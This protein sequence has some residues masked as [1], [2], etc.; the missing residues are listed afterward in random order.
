MSNKS[1]L[2]ESTR[3]NGPNGLQ[4]L[5]PGF[6]FIPNSSFTEDNN[7]ENGLDPKLIIAML[8]RYKWIVLLFLVM[9]G[10][11]A[12]LYADFVT[13]TYQSKGTLLIS[14][15]AS[16]DDL[17]RIV[18]QTT[19]VGAN[20]TLENELQILKSRSFSNQIANKISTDNLG[21]HTEYPILWAEEEDGS[22]TK[23]SVDQVASRIRNG[24]EFRKV[25]DEADIIEISFT[26]SSPKEAALIVNEAMD[27][28]VQSSIDQNRQAADSTAEFLKREKEKN[29]RK[30]EEAEQKLAK[31]MDTTGIVQVDEQ[32]STLVNER[33]NT[34]VELQ[35]VNLEIQTI[36]QTISNYEKELEA[37][38]PGLS[39]QFSEAIG[40]RIRASQ[41]ELARHE[42][43]R[44]LIIAKNPGVLDRRPVPPRLEYLDKQIV[45][46]KNEIKDLSSRLFT[47]DNTF[48]GLDGEDRAQK[49]AEIEGR[50][51]D[52][53]IQRNQY[54]SRRAAL[55]DHKREMDSNFNELPEGMIQL[56]KLKRDVRI[57]EELYT[58][59][60]KKY[61]D[62][63][64][65][66]QSQ[67]GYGRIIDLG[68]EP[69][70]PVSPNK[71]LFILLGLMLGGFLAAAYITI[72]E[73]LDDSV[74]SADQLR[75]IYVP[76]VTLTMIPS[77]ENVSKKNKKYYLS[78]KSEI[79]EEMVLLY[80]NVSPVAESIRRLKNNLIYQHGDTPPKTI[81]V[82]SP[83]KGDGKSTIVSNLGVAFASEGYKTLVIDADFRRPKLQKYFG[84]NNKKGLSDY[85]DA[86]ISID[87]LIQKSEVRNLSV[88]VAGSIKENP[89]NIGG[90]ILFKQFLNKMEDVFDV[91]LIDTP[92]FGIIS[93]SAA[94]LKGAEV[95]VVVARHRKTNKGMLLRTID[96]LSRIN[97]NVTEI[98]L[99]DFD[100]HKEL[101]STYGNGYY[102]SLYSNYEE[103]V[104]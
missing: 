98:V 96:E 67:F 75:T 97:A 77:F 49:V 52:L 29:K 13:P 24:M 6:Q 71:K 70:Y 7:D 4:R 41:E 88:V 42:N 90:N 54:I 32:A 51:V 40:P 48:L 72:R 47:G 81:A 79:P 28:Y 11:G 43:E 66:K 22:F 44:T 34:E 3:K 8:L 33:S 89:E 57:N 36:E 19:G 37:I 95:T 84:L 27:I 59:V 18:A 65:W 20:A 83:E 61:A 31:F 56:A 14:S 10:L 86:T 5:Q 62:M 85:L 92:P 68:E 99:N 45:R 60:S 55:E 74:K 17:S 16:Q 2:P 50:L 58:N 69:Y 102:Q 82:T 87:Q 35:H 23:A 91:I 9:G 63:S 53:R 93:D 80:N 100:H 73:F 25:E 101:G 39:E 21:Y 94:L 26:S 76:S 15:E 38:K 46:L 64:A 30:L 1:N 78:G 12:F 103:Y 104:Q